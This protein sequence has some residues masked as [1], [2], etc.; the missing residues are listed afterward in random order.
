MLENYSDLSARYEFRLRKSSD[1]SLGDGKLY[2]NFGYTKYLTLTQKLLMYMIANMC[3]NET[4]LACLPTGGG[5]SLSWEL[6]ALSGQ[7]SGMAIVVV[8]TIALACDHE[9]SSQQA[10]NNSF[11]APGK[12]LAYHSNL[13]Y[14]K[15]EALL[16]DIREGKV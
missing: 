16:K 14:F 9:K 3:T 8:P 15:K 5:K 1:Y 7:V 4:L 10:F 2:S 13:D 11:E 6:P 12:V